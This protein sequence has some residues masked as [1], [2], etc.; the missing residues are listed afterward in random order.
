MDH[1]QILK[2]TMR[3]AGDPRLTAW[4]E[5]LIEKGSEK[6]LLDD[7][8]EY[9]VTRR[10]QLQIQVDNLAPDVRSYEAR[11]EQEFQVRCTELEGERA[12]PYKVV[13]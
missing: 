8:L 7:K 1:R 10:D 12:R 6:R 11:E 5:A 2:E 3:A 13:S 4:Y 9:D